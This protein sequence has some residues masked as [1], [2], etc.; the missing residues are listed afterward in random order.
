MDALGGVAVETAWLA[1]LGEEK[2]LQTF[3]AR[4]SCGGG[5]K[6]FDIGG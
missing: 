4:R 6:F 3:K 1:G 5:E 2:C